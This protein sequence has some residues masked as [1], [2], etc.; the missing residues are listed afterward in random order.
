MRVFQTDCMYVCCMIVEKRAD[1]VSGA[2][3]GS[4]TVFVIHLLQCYFLC[5]CLFQAVCVDRSLLVHT[6]RDLSTALTILTVR[7]TD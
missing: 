3:H 7:I 2:K 1:V 4:M 5:C 6:V